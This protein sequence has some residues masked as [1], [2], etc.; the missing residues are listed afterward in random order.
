M[1]EQITVICDAGKVFYCYFEGTHYIAG[2]NGCETEYF[3]DTPEEAIQELYE[4]NTWK[5]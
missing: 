3:N 4:S 5:N 1:N 2:F